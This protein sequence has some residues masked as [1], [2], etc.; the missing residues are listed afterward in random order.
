MSHSPDQ[1]APTSHVLVADRQSGPVLEEARFDQHGY[2]PNAGPAPY[3][4]AALT[5]P[6]ATTVLTGELM[7]PLLST[8]HPWRL[9][10]GEAPT[11]FPLPR[12]ID[13]VR[14]GMGL[15]MAAVDEMIDFGHPVGPLLCCMTH[16]LLLVPVPSGTADVWRAAHSQCERG[17]SLR[18]SSE[19]PNSSCHHRYWI[20]PPTA[21]THPTTD[22][23]VLHHRLSLMRA[24]MRNASH[25]PTGLMCHV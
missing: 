20:A 21:L 3:A 17:P 23:A 9:Q 4:Q 16:R 10:F 8:R 1:N 5:N 22:P 12:A 13:C 25:Q 15:G 19:A 2:S 18:C 7:P 11:P 6:T 14:V 24:R